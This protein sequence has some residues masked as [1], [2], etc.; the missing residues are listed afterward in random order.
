MILLISAAP[1]ASPALIWTEEAG[2]APLEK[3]QTLF[4]L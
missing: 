2:L 4:Q 3:S 1:F